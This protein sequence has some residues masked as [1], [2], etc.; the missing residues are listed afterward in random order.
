MYQRP[1]PPL[2]PVSPG[3]HARSHRHEGN[4]MTV[5]AIPAA[6]ARSRGILGPRGA[7]MA[8]YIAAS[9]DEVLPGSYG[10]SDGGGITG[11]QI[12]HATRARACHDPIYFFNR[13]G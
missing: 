9:G 10:L 1:P 13:P 7:R 11:D 6:P 3:L 12:R 4:P 5:T 2:L 8:P